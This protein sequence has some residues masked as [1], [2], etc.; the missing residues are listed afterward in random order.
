MKLVEVLG[1]IKANGSNARVIS[2]IFLI[3]FI[4]Q[5]PELLKFY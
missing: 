3:E 1:K 4:L 2:Y 5:L